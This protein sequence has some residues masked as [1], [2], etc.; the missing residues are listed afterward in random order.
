MAR[1]MSKARSASG[2][3]AVAAVDLQ[4]TWERA[5]QEGKRA[6]RAQ[7]GGQQVSGAA[8]RKHKFILRVQLATCS[9][10]TGDECLS[11]LQPT[12]V[13]F[14]VCHVRQAQQSAPERIRARA[15]P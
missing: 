13:L 12:I 9:L 14:F 6:A 15:L 2:S 5:L 3:F 11:Q 1:C 7:R 10:A 4:L 8:Q